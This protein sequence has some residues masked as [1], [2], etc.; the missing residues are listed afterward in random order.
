MRRGDVVL[1]YVPFVGAKGGKRRPA[2]VVQNDSLNAAIRET[3]LVEITSNVS[4]AARPHHVLIDVATPDG[5]STGLLTDSVIRCER[6]HTVPQAD[7]FQ[8]I[9]A[10]S[11]TLLRLLDDGLKAAFGIL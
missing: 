1:V 5:A 8:T 10:L 7:I 3:V 2:V 6:P 11:P 9:G 4:R